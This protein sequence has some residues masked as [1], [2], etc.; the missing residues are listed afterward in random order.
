[1]RVDET[2]GMG[3][4]YE[5]KRMWL[6][7]F[8]YTTSGLLGKIGWVIAA[9]FMNLV[10]FTWL[11][12]KLLGWLLTALAISL[13]APFWFDL[14][15]KVINIRGAGGKPDIVDDGVKKKSK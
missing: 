4:T 2:M 5:L 6:P 11:F 13:G 8:D 1:M 3:W 15:K 7:N 12:P 9:F 14:L 10:H